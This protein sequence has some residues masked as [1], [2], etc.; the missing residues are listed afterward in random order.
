MSGSDIYMDHDER[1]RLRREARERRRSMRG[2]SD[3]LAHAVRG[4][5]TLITVGVLFAVN[6]FTPYGFDKTWPV[7]LIVFGLLTLVGR[8]MAPVEPPAPQ[9][10]AA[11]PPNFN[12]TPPASGYRESSYA[13]PPA[14]GEAGPAATAKGGFG[15]SAPPKQGDPE[16][17][18]GGS[19]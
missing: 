1:R 18:P 9:P 5:L 8:G 10:P 17:T 3:S 19:I 16:Q 12:F 13:Q 4:P 6:N 14:S 15:T 11:S 2:Q 7:I